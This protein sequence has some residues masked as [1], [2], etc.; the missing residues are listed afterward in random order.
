M[1]TATANDLVHY[2]LERGL[3]SVANVVDGLRVVPT[4]RRNNN[5]SVT[6][7]SGPGYFVKTLL[8]GAAQAAETLRQEATLYSVAASEEAFEPLR[9]L[10]PRFHFYDPQRTLLVVEHLGEAKTLGELH[11]QLGGAMEWV[12]ERTGRAIASIHRAGAAALPR[13]DPHAFRRQPPWA[14]SLHQITPQ[15]G[16][17]GMQLQTLL[18]TY[19]EYGQALDAMRAGWRMNTVIHGDMKFDNVL[20]IGGGSDWTLKIVD[21]E[22][23]DLG[24]DLWDVAG[25]LQNYLYWSA[26]S[27]QSGHG[28]WTVSMPF[29]QLQP[30]MRALWTAYCEE[31]GTPEPDRTPRLERCV[32]YAAAR[33]LQSVMEMLVVSPVMSSHVALLLQTSLNILR[34]PALMA[35]LVVNAPAEA[36]HV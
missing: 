12:A 4:V 32:L 5:F 27:T 20:M 26:I 15:F 33:L 22:L 13:L 25:I 3:L 7:R 8:P 30:S 11:A 19:P 18:L 21:W 14:L 17:P 24:E 29:E 34:D 6:C 28:G 2:L 36:A 16:Q 35:S 1:L 10:L 31:L 9:A 23:S